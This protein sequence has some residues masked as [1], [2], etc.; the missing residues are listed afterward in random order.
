MNEPLKQIELKQIDWSKPLLRVDNQGEVVSVL[1]SNVCIY[2]AG[3]RGWL[4]D[5]CKDGCHDI[6]WLDK[7]GCEYGCA[8]PVIRN[9]P[10]KPVTLKRWANVYKDESEPDGHRIC[11]HESEESAKWQFPM[12]PA[13]AVPVTVTYTPE[14]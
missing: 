10:P 5:I 1:L 7:F 3:R 9:V 8:F 11:F 2:C 4:V 14:E 6:H 13:C 12:K